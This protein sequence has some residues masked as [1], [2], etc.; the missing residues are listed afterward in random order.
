MSEL[1]DSSYVDLQKLQPDDEQVFDPKLV[2]E[3]ENT[4]TPPVFQSEEWHDYVMMQFADNEL[5]KGNPIRDG[6]VR[7]AE[8]L[9]GPIT[10]REIVSFVD[11]S[12][13]NRGSATVHIRLTLLL[14]NINH[15]LYEKVD[16]I[17][18]DGI[19]EANSRNSP[20][21]YHLH[22]AA[23]ASSKAEAQALRKALR[24]RRTVAADEITP[25]DMVMDGDIYTPDSPITSEQITLIDLLCRRVNISLLDFIN[26]GEIKYAFIEQIPTSK[27]QRMLKFLN[28]IQSGKQKSP[29]SKIYDPSWR[30]KNNQQRMNTNENST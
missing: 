8:N 22:P 11:A 25:E 10:R 24:L 17:I 18:E 3:V 14:T 19:A 13:E 28:E 12:S 16:F 6:L 20:A 29:I 23:T 7:V 26:S 2:E 30:E 15:P 9:I 4:I 27:A 5:D 1:D 21:P